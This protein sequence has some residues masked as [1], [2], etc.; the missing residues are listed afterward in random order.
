MTSLLR[1]W[2]LAL[3]AVAGLC[4]VAWL[5]PQQLSVTLYKGV[6]IA[7]GG[8]LG[9]WVDRH[10]FPYARPTQFLFDKAPDT[11]EGWASYETRDTA[12]AKAFRLAMLRRAIIVAACIVATAVGL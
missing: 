8:Y 12:E 1:V 9:Y 10:V 6:L 3:L 11:G 7:L 2:F 4:A 5:A